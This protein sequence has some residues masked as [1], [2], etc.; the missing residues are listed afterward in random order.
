M[1]KGRITPSRFRARYK[2]FKKELIVLEGIQ[3]CLSDL[4]IE[5]GHLALQDHIRLA[6]M[7]QHKKY[8]VASDLFVA[9][10]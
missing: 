8:L 9:A 2:H 5:R 10:S 7:N 3:V 6:E 4:V 1:F